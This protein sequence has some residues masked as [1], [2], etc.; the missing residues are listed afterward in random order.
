MPK[1]A[2][3]QPMLSDERYHEINRLGW[4]NTDWDKQYLD[5]TVRPEEKLADHVVR[6][7]FGK[8][9]FSHSMWI[10]ATDVEAAFSV[11]NGYYGNPDD[12][13]P[14]EGKKWRSLSVG[15]V[16]LEPYGVGWLCLPV[17]FCDLRPSTTRMLRDLI[18]K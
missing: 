17:G 11:G 7:A 6:E 4:G 8:D 14:V 5:L 10:E 18:G 13:R 16:L 9:L 3:L 2:V 1:Y 12:L 15:D